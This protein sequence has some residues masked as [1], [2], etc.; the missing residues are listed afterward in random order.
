[1]FIRMYIFFLSQVLLREK[2]VKAAAVVLVLNWQKSPSQRRRPRK[3]PRMQKRPLRRTKA[4]RQLLAA[5]SLRQVVLKSPR[6]RLTGWRACWAIMAAIL[7]PNK[8]LSPNITSCSAQ[9]ARILTFKP[10][11][12]MAFIYYISKAFFVARCKSLPKT[13]RIGDISACYFFRPALVF[14]RGSLCDTKELF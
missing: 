11:K 14:C 9:H 7:T 3:I 2:V 12:K 6:R 8:P 1:M 4:R 5:K 10:D 13:F